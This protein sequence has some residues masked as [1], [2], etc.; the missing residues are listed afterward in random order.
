MGCSK[1]AGFRVPLRVLPVVALVFGFL[2][3]GNLTAG[4]PNDVCADCHEISET[5]HK[6]P[7]A[8][9]FADDP[10]LAENSC[11]ACHGSAVDHVNE[12]DPELILNPADQD[13]FGSSLLCL[14]CHDDHQFDDWSFSSHNGADVNCSG[15]HVVHTG[16]TP[17]KKDGPELCYE[18]HSD[19]RAAAHMP[20]HHP[21]A[22]GK[23][24]C[25]DC[26]NVHGGA[27]R[28]ADGQSSQELCYSCHAWVEGPWVY[29]HAPV[30]E[31]CMTCHK[32]HGTVA[33]NL[34]KQ[35]EPAL[36]LNCHSMHF[37]ATVEGAEGTLIPPA[38]STIT[39][40][41]TQ[42]GWKRGM[43]TKCTQCHSMVHGSDMP[44]QAI[45]SG[46]TGLTR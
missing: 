32:P 22:E 26:H 39:L 25:Y 29:E 45:S 31:D 15:C 27:T 3:T 20:S 16:Y 24:S 37:H 35:S 46:G 12:G 6:T 8:V 1:K 23:M 44:S 28:F 36:C 30:T 9:Y 43:L 4:V 33:N 10:E 2:L 19:V 18:C 21:I 40:R 14:N 38:D 11:E 7:H 34:L 13:Q 5:F 17:A 41:S 42:D